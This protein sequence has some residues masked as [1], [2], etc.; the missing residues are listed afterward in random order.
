MPRLPALIPA[1]LLLAGCNVEPLVT[2]GIVAG[3][4]LVVTG[5]TPLDHVA[6]LVT[7]QD[8]SAV[9][10]ERR[11]PWCVPHPGPP[12]PPPFCTRSLGSVDC[13]TDPPP[14]APAQGVADPGVGPRRPPAAPP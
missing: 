5:K 8:C 4:S 1:V 7:G 2:G 9:R 6:G 3:A 12:E 11:G 13:W 14:G 10:Y